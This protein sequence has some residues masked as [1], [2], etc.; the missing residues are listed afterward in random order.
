M[1]GI[2]LQLQYVLPLIYCYLMMGIV[3][4][5]AELPHRESSFVKT[6]IQE[7][8][9]GIHLLFYKQTVYRKKTSIGKDK[10]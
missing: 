4:R 9:V 2:A 6:N 10:L 5:K 1:R 7:S 8:C 3:T